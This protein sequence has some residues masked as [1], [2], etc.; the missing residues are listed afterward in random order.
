MERLQAPRPD[1]SIPFVREKESNYQKSWAG[2]VAGSPNSSVPKK[3]SPYGA[4]SAPLASV[5][6][7]IA[8]PRTPV[9][10]SQIP[11]QPVSAPASI[12]PAAIPADLSSIMA[13]AIE[14]AL[15]PMKEPTIILMQRTLE[16]LQAE[17]V[18]LRAKEK[19]DA[20]ISK[21]AADAK[22]MRTDSD[23]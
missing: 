18:A 23:K 6:I 21:A 20:M 13:A 14:A 16:S 4:V 5:T 12:S 17:F 15:K 1:R 7:A 11:A 9:T 19:D 8:L 10:G 22:R 2:I 3:P